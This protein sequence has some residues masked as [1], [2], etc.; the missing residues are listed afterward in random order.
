MIPSK[1][2]NFILKLKLI[3]NDSYLNYLYICMIILIRNL[4]SLKILECFQTE[5]PELLTV[6]KVT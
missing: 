1:S 4:I 5:V 3:K 2:I 6:F